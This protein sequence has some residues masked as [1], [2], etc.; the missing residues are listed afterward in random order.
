[1][2]QKLLLLLITINLYAAG[3]AK[4]NNL[5]NKSNNQYFIENKGQWPSN[6]FYNVKIGGQGKLILLNSAIFLNSL[7]PKRL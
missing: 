5:S 2:I 6:V 7:R 3:F 4:E 1:M